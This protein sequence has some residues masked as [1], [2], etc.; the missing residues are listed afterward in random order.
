MLRP[1]ALAP[2]TVPGRLVLGLCAALFLAERL[3]EAVGV[4]PAWTAGTLDDLVCM[5]LVLSLVT[6]A[7]RLGGRAPAWRLPVVHGLAVTAAYA[8][9]FEVLLPRWDARATGDPRDVLAYAAGFAVY[10][11]V[12][13][14][15]ARPAART[16]V[17]EPCIPP[18]AG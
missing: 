12:V 3:A 16:R 1:A 14:R 10:H 7:Q 13:G 4:A 5:P 17:T 2:R 11:L 8:L 15:R 6:A 18:R 9:F